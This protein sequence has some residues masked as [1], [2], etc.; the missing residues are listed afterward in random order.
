MPAAAPI[1]MAEN[2]FTKPLAGVMATSPATHP[3]IPPRTLGLPVW[4]HSA[5]S[6]A[7]AAAAAPKWVATKALVASP[8]AARALPALKPNQPT[9]SRQAPMKL[10]TRLCGFTGVLG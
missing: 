5:A 1:H 3:E 10:S 7:S 4:I 2:G 9:Q 8:L 6:Q